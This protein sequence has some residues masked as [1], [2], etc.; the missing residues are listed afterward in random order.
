MN[1][2]SILAL[3]GAMVVPLGGCLRSE[4]EDK[5]SRSR[6]SARV[7]SEAP[8]NATVYSSDS[9]LIDESPF[10]QSLLDDAVDDGESARED[11]LSV[12][13]YE[14]VVKITEQLQMHSGE[15]PRGYY[16]E[17]RTQIVVVSNSILDSS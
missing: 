9:E 1:R 3:S 15:G 8:D 13:E 17:H 7:E 6:V 2:R 5:A 12:E 14:E 4:E 11:G 10:L 16:M